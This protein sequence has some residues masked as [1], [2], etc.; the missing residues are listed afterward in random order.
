MF[1]FNVFVKFYIFSIEFIDKLILGYGSVLTDSGEVEM[2]ALIMD[3]KAMRSG[4]VGAVSCV[5]NP[6]D[7]ARYDLFSD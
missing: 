5:K 6:V 3:G 7:L 2:D 1:E 4:A